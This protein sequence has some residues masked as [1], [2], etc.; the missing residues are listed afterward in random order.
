MK[1]IEI[2]IKLQKVSSVKKSRYSEENG[3]SRIKDKA[4]TT[5]TEKVRLDFHK[6]LDEIVLFLLYSDGKSDI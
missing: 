6:L 2:D 1:Y 5:K 3:R 4:K